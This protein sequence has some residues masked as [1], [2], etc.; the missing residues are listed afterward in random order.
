MSNLEIVGLIVSVLGVGCFAAVFTILYV[1]YSNSIISEYKS[2]K[3]DIELI[4]ESIY[5]NLNKV[6]LVAKFKLIK[7]LCGEIIKH[8]KLWQI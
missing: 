3:K 1:T 5:D 4:D 7:Y 8:I 6:K 2:G